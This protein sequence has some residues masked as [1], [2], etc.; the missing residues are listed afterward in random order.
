MKDIFYIS[1]FLSPRQYIP[2]RQLSEINRRL[3]KSLNH[4]N[5]KLISPLKHNENLELLSEPLITSSA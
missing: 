1:F 2:P 5:E 4:F 3:S